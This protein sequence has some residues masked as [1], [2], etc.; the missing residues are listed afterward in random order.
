[1]VACRILASL[2]DVPKANVVLV[3]DGSPSIAADKFVL[4]QQFAKDTVEA[5]A[6]R[7]IFD[8]GG[9]ASYV[10]FSATTFDEGT[11]NSSESF[12]AHVDTVVQAGSG[13]DIVEG[14]QHGRT[15]VSA[16]Y[17]FVV[18]CLVVFSTAEHFLGNGHMNGRSQPWFIASA[19]A[20]RPLFSQSGR[21]SSASN[22]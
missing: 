16:T 18:I 13:T 20:D 17:Y 10:Q 2:Y 6:R 15:V 22:T 19:T 1:M 3:V 9:T 7:G 14:T 12:N 4:E 21:E 11:F 8:K 5:F